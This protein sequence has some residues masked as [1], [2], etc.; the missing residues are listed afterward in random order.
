MLVDFNLTQS[1]WRNVWL[2]QT[3]RTRLAFNA[4]RRK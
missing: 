2:Y 3:T 4:I 1:R